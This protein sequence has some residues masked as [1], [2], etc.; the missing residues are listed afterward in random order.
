MTTIHTHTCQLALLTDGLMQEREFG[1]V[2]SRGLKCTNFNQ[3]HIS[4]EKLLNTGLSEEL[5]PRG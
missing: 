2:D 4:H 5:V 1:E 3:I